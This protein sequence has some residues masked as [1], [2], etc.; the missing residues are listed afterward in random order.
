MADIYLYPT[1]R[2]R[3]KRS[4]SKRR[5]IG[6]QIVKLLQVRAAKLAAEQDAAKNAETIKAHRG[7][8]AQSESLVKQLRYELAKLVQIT[9]KS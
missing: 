4:G 1:E 8:I 7:V 3:Q 2:A 5:A 9:G 6:S